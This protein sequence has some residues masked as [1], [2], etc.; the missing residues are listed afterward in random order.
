MDN[1]TPILVIDDDPATKFLIEMLVG[2]IDR[3]YEV[4]VTSNG[5]E[6]FEYLTEMVKPPAFIF[7]DLNM[8]ILNGWDFLLKYENLENSKKSV[9]VVIMISN[10]SDIIKARE[11]VG[12][13]D[14][15]VFL[16][17]PVTEDKLRKVLHN[18]K[19]N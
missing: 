2:K 7:L 1:S 16:E 3:Q 8:P 17:K 13:T 5:L 19:K 14:K 6:G 11:I 12:E 4:K 18:R 10:I 9:Y 15:L